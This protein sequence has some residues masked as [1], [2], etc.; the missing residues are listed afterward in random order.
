MQ[1]EGGSMETVQFYKYLG[2]VL[3]NKLDWTTN[4]DHQEEPVQAV[5]SL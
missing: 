1:T 5:L 3:D 4:T 2:V